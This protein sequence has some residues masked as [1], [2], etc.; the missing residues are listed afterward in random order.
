MN[1]NQTKP[2]LII[3]PN[4]TIE[5]ARQKKNDLYP[6]EGRGHLNNIEYSVEAPFSLL[7]YYLLLV[8]DFDI[9]ISLD[10][11]YDGWTKIATILIVG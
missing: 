9:T 3:E 2:I 7:S 11:I 10:Q 1:Q 5:V 4:F 6:L 8:C